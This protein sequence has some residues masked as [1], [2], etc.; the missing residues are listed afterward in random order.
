MTQKLTQNVSICEHIWTDLIVYP[1][2]TENELAWALLTYI[3]LTFQFFALI[4]IFIITNSYIKQR[5]VK[6]SL[7]L[8][9]IKEKSSQINLQMQSF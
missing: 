4:I 2:M 1:T 7:F 5:D 8:N 9:L 3:L 6:V